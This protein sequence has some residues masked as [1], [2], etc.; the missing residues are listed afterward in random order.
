MAGNKP[1]SDAAF[2]PETDVTLISGL[3]GFKSGTPNT[4]VKISGTDLKNSVLLGAVTSFTN[5]FGTFVTGTVNS[6]ATGAVN[7]GSLDLSATG[8]TDSTTFLRG[9]NTWAVPPNDNDNTTYTYA[10]TQSSAGSDDDPFLTLTGSDA[11]IDN[12]KLIGGTSIGIS[13]NTA[14]DEVTIT[15]TGTDSDTTYDL[16]TAS[17][18]TFGQIDL[19]GSDGTTDS[20]TLTGAGTVS[21]TS[22]AAGAITITGAAGSASAFTNKTGGATIDWDYATDGPNIKLT[23]TSGEENALVVSDI[24]EFPDGSSGFLI[25]D[26]V[27][28][29]TYRLPSEDYGSDTGI[30]SLVTNGDPF[31]NGSN[32]VRLQ[33]VYDGSTFWFDIDT[34]MIEPIYPPTVEFDSTNLIG[35][36]HPR[37]YPQATIGQVNGSA[38]PVLPATSATIGDLVPG[39][40]GST[41]EYYP[42]T[43][44]TPAYF[45]FGGTSN[46]FSKNIAGSV[47]AVASASFYF[48][49]PADAGDCGLIDFYDGSGIYTECLYLIDREFSL[50]TPGF[51]FG[52]PQLI[53]YTGTGGA[54]LLNDWI[55][56]TV[57]ID[58]VS[59]EITLW[60]G[61]QASLDAAV[62][63]GGATAWNY[64][65]TLGNTVNV[66][67]NGLYKEVASVTISELTW[68]RIFYG[69]SAAN[70]ESSECHMGM[71]GIYDV[72]LN[73]AAVTTNWVDSRGTYF[74]T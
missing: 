12:I 26:P 7:I 17:Q 36:W 51:T 30:Q 3:A 22:D 57:A 40:I 11:S 60:V 68:D 14:G 58:N 48:Q 52:Y 44:T 39:G 16:G 66:D 37:S 53:N 47:T 4:N 34:N 41:F 32:P 42:N 15:Y 71:L 70:S 65:G 5:A 6:S 74:I 35:F 73:D 27:N 20:V 24:N 43:A 55:F 63:A 67:A 2:A 9:D 69:N 38:W 49:Q 33:W 64:D 54:N 72:L 18:T 10:S 59:N 62:A 28:T 21:V 50:Y 45:S 19:T 61:T 23:M 8:T 1:I 56:C 13:R 29:T 31:T 46:R 25:L